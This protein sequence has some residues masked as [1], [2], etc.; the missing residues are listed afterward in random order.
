MAVAGCR[1]LPNPMRFPELPWSRFPGDEDYAPERAKRRRVR[2]AWIA[3]GVVVL[4]AL[5][6]FVGWP[7]VQTWSAERALRRA[8]EAITFKDYKQAQLLLEQ[9]VQLHPKHHEA[10]RQLADFYARGKSPESLR[11]WKEV[12]RLEPENDANWFGLANAALQF[13][14]LP[15]ARTALEGVSRNAKTGV[16]YK[17]YAAG[18][19]LAAGDRNALAEA[20][21]GMAALDPSNVRLQFDS[22]AL[23][24]L[25]KTPSEAA[26]GRA[27]MEALA[28]GETL[29]IRATLA[30]LRVTQARKQPQPAPRGTSAV[31]SANAGATPAAV[32]TAVAATTSV[33]VADEVAQA[34]FDSGKS[35]ASASSAAVPAAATRT[36]AAA[37]LTSID[38]L[39]VHMKAQPAPNAVDAADLARWLLE[40]GRTQEASNWFTTL[41]AAILADPTVLQLRAA[42]AVRLRDWAVLETTLLAGAWGVLPAGMAEAAFDAQ[43]R[44]AL[45]DNDGATA[46]WG[47]A[48]DRAGTSRGAQQVL[49]RLANE[50]RWQAGVERTLVKILA[51]QPRD[52]ALWD[53]LVTTA[54]A[55]GGAADALEYYDNWVQAVP[56]NVLARA[57][58]ALLAVILND[59]DTRTRETLTDPALQSQ[60][61]AALVAARA[62]R[63]W[64]L[65]DKTLARETLQ[66][67]PPASTLTD[68]KEARV[69]LVGG[70][71]WAELGDAARSQTYLYDVEKD[72]AVLK[73]AEERKLLDAARVR[74]RTPTSTPTPTPTSTPTSSS[75]FTVAPSAPSA[76]V[77]TIP[78]PAS[79]ALSR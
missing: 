79:R 7:R 70:Y 58:E 42:T 35:T 48:L 55:R 1:S 54:E 19:A 32:T 37:E 52:N 67:L 57:R 77:S 53:A 30:L 31:G 22:A 43:A 75:S 64:K 16:D 28:R 5:V 71:L 68:S 38:A 18:I 9:V 46:L 27:R 45:A 23:A 69:V 66:K 20:L 11:Q 44:F 60:S 72:P 4:L 25:S 49:L 24:L 65:G 76:A 61:P 15:L 12:A 29:R 59:V 14:D 41:P 47:Q 26:V 63:Y 21:A 73:L 3:G 40:N 56:E 8:N 50:F 17:R 6:V 78:T 33:A 13:G 34:I 2:L 10:R 62:L 36:S 51:L 74:N 39:I